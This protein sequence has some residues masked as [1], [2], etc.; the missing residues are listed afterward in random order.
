MKQNTVSINDLFQTSYLTTR[1]AAQVIFKNVHQDDIFDF[2]DIEFA[3]SSFVDEFMS[4]A[5]QR[6][7]VVHDVIQNVN[8][9]LERLFAAVQKRRQLPL[10]A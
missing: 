2:S 5:E 4:Q 9:S 10:R 6:G 8:P 1:E 7:I 3:S